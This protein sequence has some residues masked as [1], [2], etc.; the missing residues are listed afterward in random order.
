[1]YDEAH[2]FSFALRD[3]SPKGGFPRSSFQ[4]SCNTVSVRFSKMIRSKICKSENNLNLVL[5]RDPF[6][7]S[8]KEDAQS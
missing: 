2:S 6:R 1:M 7:E 4:D 8:R 3:C 5:V